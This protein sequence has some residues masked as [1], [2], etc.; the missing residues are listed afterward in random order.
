MEYTKPEITSVASAMD[1][2]QSNTLK[3]AVPVDSNKQSPSGAY[4]SDEE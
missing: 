4:E 2:V 3:I 1:A